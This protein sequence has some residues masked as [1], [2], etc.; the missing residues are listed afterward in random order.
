MFT[1]RS[2]QHQRTLWHWQLSHGPACHP[3][4]C[5]VLGP[6]APALRRARIRGKGLQQL[7]L[8]P[9]CA[10]QSNEHGTQ[11]NFCF[12]FAT[13]WHHDPSES[14]PAQ[15]CGPY[16]AKTPCQHQFRLGKES[17]RDRRSAAPGA[18]REQP[19]KRFDLEWQHSVLGWRWTAS[20][21]WM[22]WHT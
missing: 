9:L 3:Q 5:V 18:G 20:R 10:G 13:R 16:W 19:L 2:E 11:S 17:P 12:I 6:G 8:Q 4:G 22:L 21:F 15:P 1:V 7:H 14:Q